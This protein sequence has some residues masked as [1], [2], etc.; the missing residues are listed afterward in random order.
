[1]KYKA[2]PVAK[3]WKLAHSTRP[4]L[5]GRVF[6]LMENLDGE[7]FQNFGYAMT[8]RRDDGSN[9]NWFDNY[10]QGLCYDQNTIKFVIISV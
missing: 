5:F 3:F 4:D 9:Q 8:R 1:M 10:K 6:L 7:L 2:V